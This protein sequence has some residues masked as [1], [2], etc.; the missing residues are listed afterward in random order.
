MESTR[1][2][3]RPRRLLL[4]WIAIYIVSELAGAGAEAVV[5]G[6]WTN[7]ILLSMTLS[8]FAAG[9]IALRRGRARA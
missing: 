3:E 6:S 8:C 4:T 7:A 5:P 1:R 9:W 2:G